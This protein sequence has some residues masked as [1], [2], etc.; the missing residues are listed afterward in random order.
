[1]KA[2]FQIAPIDA[3]CVRTIGDCVFNQFRRSQCEARSAE[4]V[5]QL[6]RLVRLNTSLFDINLASNLVV[7]WPHSIY[8]AAALANVNNLLLELHMW[9]CYSLSLGTDTNC[10]ASAGWSG[11]GGNHADCPSTPPR[12]RS[13]RRQAGHSVN[14][15]H[16][17]FRSPL[18]HKCESLVV[19]WLFPFT[20][21]SHYY[22]PS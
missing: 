12:T 13:S 4:S 15:I 10:S 3:K 19:C 18:L 17:I 21:F 2:S 14:G 20:V 22:A 1:M 16:S 7:S 11:R 5:A 6:Y 8:W 9:A